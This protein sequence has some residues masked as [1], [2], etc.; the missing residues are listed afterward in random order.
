MEPK[1]ILIGL[2][3]P[4]QAVEEIDRRIEHCFISRQDFIRDLIYTELV[5]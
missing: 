3:L 5:E 4:R 1:T 2:R